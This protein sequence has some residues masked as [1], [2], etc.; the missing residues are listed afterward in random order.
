M[1][2]EHEHKH[3]YENEALYKA[4][5]ERIVHV[6]VTHVHWLRNEIARLDEC[7]Y[8]SKILKLLKIN[9]ATQTINR[10]DNREVICV[11]CG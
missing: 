3:N 11:G 7:G 1:Q 5:M 4:Q 6:T 9:E 10:L 8:Y 2:H